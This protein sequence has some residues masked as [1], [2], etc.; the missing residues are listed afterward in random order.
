MRKQHQYPSANYT[1]LSNKF[2]NS[3]NIVYYCA[4][5]NSKTPDKFAR[6]KGEI[7]AK[8]MKKVKVTPR[9]NFNSMVNELLEKSLKSKER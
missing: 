6:V 9:S 2:V 3:V 5:N 7:A 4:V 8:V 1:L